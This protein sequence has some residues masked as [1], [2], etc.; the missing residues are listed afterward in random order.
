MTVAS[1]GHPLSGGRSIRE[2][3][4]VSTVAK[5]ATRISRT[6]EGSSGSVVDFIIRAIMRLA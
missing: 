3:M 5:I 6:S 4:G 1:T 2:A